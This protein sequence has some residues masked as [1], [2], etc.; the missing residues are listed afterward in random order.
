MEAELESFKSYLTNIVR[1][2]RF[3][4]TITPP[5]VMDMEDMIDLDKL[6]FYASSVVIPDR[7]FSEIEIKYYG[8]SLKIPGG[9]IIQDLTINFLLDEGW[10]SRDFFET[11][12]SFINDRDSNIKT[13]PYEL[14]EGASIV[15]SQLGFKNEILAKYQFMNIFPKTV[16]QIELSMENVDT[17]STF[18]VTFA[19]SYWEQ[20]NT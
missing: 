5:T 11:W 17:H 16:D 15:V 12:A 10:E 2:N 4:V 13:T 8:M 3:L 9:E 6:T 14:F 7:T 1:P 18:Q 19:Y 20:I